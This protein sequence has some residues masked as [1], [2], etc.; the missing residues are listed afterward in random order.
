MKCK[1]LEEQ[2]QKLQSKIGE[3]GT[4]ITDSLE[5]DLLKIIGG[6]QNLEA[7]PHMKFF[8]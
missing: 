2:L 7:T 4:N 3:E 6:G 5:K 1:S 8:W